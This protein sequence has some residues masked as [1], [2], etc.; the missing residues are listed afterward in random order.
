MDFTNI[1]RNK[2][3]YLT[4]DEINKLLKYCFDNE[5]MRD[6][7]LILVLSRTGRRITEIVGEKPYTRKVGLRPCDIIED[8]IEWD[9]LKKNPIKIKKN[10]RT[11]KESIVNELRVKKMPKRAMKTMDHASLSILNKY[12]ELNNIHPM[13]RVFPITRQRA[14]Y[15]INNIAEKSKVFRD[16]NKIHPHMF[17]HSLAINLFKDNPNDASVL[18]NVKNLLDHS[19]I[20][21]TMHYAQF[22][23][24][25]IRD[26]LEKL[27]GD[28]DV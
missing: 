14:C 19:D 23:Q 11:R 13:D 22:T 5:K 17:R 2:K 1:M 6:F 26:K 25:D 24:E 7:V 21:I 3:A 8:K 4:L 20:N 16:G 12:I 27:F 28:G 15:I 10:N 18:Q 9:I